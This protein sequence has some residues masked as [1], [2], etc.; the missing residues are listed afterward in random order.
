[1]RR[2]RW[3]NALNAI[4][5]ATFVVVAACR[6]IKQVNSLGKQIDHEFGRPI[7]VSVD[8][9]SHLVLIV[10]PA[11]ADSTQSDTTDPVNFAR[12]VA[13]YAVAHYERKAFLK[14]VTVVFDP[15]DSTTAFRNY[16]WSADD[17][18]GKKKATSGT[19][20]ARSD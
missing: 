1:M 9:Q 4:S 3:R 17:L 6:P 13:E 20:A 14:T 19:P 12:H 18:S 2:S 5:G 11:A 16:Y 15:G 8:H 7:M 10:P